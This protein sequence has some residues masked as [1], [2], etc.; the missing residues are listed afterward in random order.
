MSACTAQAALPLF[1]PTHKH[2]FFS[3]VQVIARGTAYSQT[4]LFS[5]MQDLF[6]AGPVY[7]YMLVRIYVEF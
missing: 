2:R 3:H 4:R 1:Q 6:D 7:T 5:L